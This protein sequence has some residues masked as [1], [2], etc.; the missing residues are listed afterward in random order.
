MAKVTLPDGSVL[1][2]SD[3][4][5][6]GQ[7]AEQIGPALGRAAIA[8]RVNGQLVDLS[9]SISKDTTVQILTAK[10]SEGLEIMRHSCAHIMAE[11]ICDIWPEAKLVYGPTVEDGFYYDIDLDE[12]IRPDDFER[13]EE[14]MC[15]IIKADKPFIRKEMTQ[16]EALDKLGGDK[17]KIDN[18]KHSDSD[19]IS[20][21][22]H[23]DG[24]KDLCKGPHLPSIGKVGSFK[25]MSVAGAYWHGDPTQKML[26]PLTRPHSR[27]LQL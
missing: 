18:I 2:T 23:G 4:T 27:S 8:A 1:K 25:I 14:R 17:Y 13:I 9:A 22:S 6:V 5:T 12:S 26:Q 10:D 15:E 16:A 24:F 11:A 20:F 19:V 3:G 7:L 21:Y